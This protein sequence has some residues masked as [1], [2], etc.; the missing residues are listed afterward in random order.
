MS[1]SLWD[2]DP[3]YDRDSQWFPH[4]VFSSLPPLIQMWPLRLSSKCS[5]DP[6]Q[7]SWDLLHVVHQTPTRIPPSSPQ[8]NSRQEFNEQVWEVFSTY[9]TVHWIPTLGSL[10]RFT[11]KCNIPHK[12]Q[13][14]TQDS[15]QELIYRIWKKPNPGSSRSE[16]HFRFLC[17]RLDSQSVVCFS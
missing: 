13:F 9:D 11:T 2:D 4:D 15:A 17:I 1:K 16:F 14:M 3:R 7:T 12:L 8:A 5:T 6:R 10:G